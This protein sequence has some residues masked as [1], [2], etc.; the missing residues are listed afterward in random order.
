VGLFILRVREC[1][2][3]STNY[4]ELDPVTSTHGNS[5]L[6][7][8]CVWSDNERKLLQD[9]SGHGGGDAR[10]GGAKDVSSFR[11]RQIARPLQS[12]RWGPPGWGR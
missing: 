1:L 6:R 4:V 2:P 9:M 10:G 5:A 8:H 7:I 12:T 3:R 11:G